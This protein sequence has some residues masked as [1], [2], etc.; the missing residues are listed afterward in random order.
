MGYMVA[1]G[2]KREALFEQL[3]DVDEALDYLA[4]DLGTGRW[5]TSRLFIFAIMLQRMRD[6]R[7]F[8]FL[9]QE[10]D[11]GG[12]F[13]GTASPDKV[14]WALAYLAPG[15]QIC[16]IRNWASDKDLRIG[17]SVSMLQKD[18]AVPITIDVQDVWRARIG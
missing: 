8:V 4:I 1:P 15:S 3:E 5:L 11:E 14:R 10:G 16:E 18:V 17:I 13:L 9:A 12:R 6:L 7:C 2:S